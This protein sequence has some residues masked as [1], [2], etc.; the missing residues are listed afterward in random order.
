M[1]WIE[2]RHPPG[3]VVIST[4]LIM[5][6]G[7]A[8]DSWEELLVPMGT[9]RQKRSGALVHDQLNRGIFKALDEGAQWVWITGDDHGHKFDVLMRLLD[10][11]LPVVT[12]LVL[13]RVPPFWTHITQ[14]TAET[15][16]GFQPKPLQDMPR[17]TGL[18]HLAPD[19][20]CGDAGMLIRREVLERLGN[21]WYRAVRFPDID[22]AMRIRD[23]GVPIAVDLSQHM[24]HIA[25]VS[26]EPV[27]DEGGWHAQ[28]TMSGD[29]NI[30]TGEREHKP[31]VRLRMNL[32]SRPNGEMVGEE[33]EMV[34][35]EA[36]V[37]HLSAL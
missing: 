37:D 14:R 4:Q 6:Y 28:F 9:K 7:E 17:H 32:T 35:E 13:G 20:A 31:F 33:A 3:A 12:P 36:E 24:S 21:P 5:R 23:L 30:S 2:S 19:E 8:L 15:P 18:Y 11:D 1:H 22:L 29:F 26:I 34:G 10:L 25:P 27:L 16:N